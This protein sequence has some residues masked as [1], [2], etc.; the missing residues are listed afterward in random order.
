MG[1][2]RI[3]NG[4]ITTDNVEVT[5][6]TVTS[7]LSVLSDAQID[8]ELTVAGRNVLETIDNHN[9]ALENHANSI[10]D[11]NPHLTVAEHERFNKIARLFE[12]V[13]ADTSFVPNIIPSLDDS[14]GT[15]VPD[16]WFQ[17]TF[18]KENA[19]ENWPVNKAPGKV[20]VSRVPY[21]A[22]DD[23]TG[24][25]LT[26]TDASTIV[27]SVVYD[28]LAS[29]LMDNTDLEH[30]PSTDTVEGKDDYVGK[31]WAFFWNYGNFARDEYGTKHI[32]AV[33]D[34]TPAWSD[35]DGVT[36]ITG[37]AFDVKKNTAA[38]GP[39]FWF[40]CKVENYTDPNGE[41][42]VYPGTDKPYT[43]LWGI[44]DSPWDTIDDTSELYNGIVY[45][46]LSDDRKADLEAHGITKND[47]HIWPSALVWTGEKYVIRPYWCEAAFAGGYA[48]GSIGLVS[49]ANAPLWNNM[50]LST[51]YSTSVNG[52]TSKMAAHGS[53]LFGFHTLFTI[54]KSAN[55]NSQ[56]LYSGFTS[57][58]V[59]SV[60]ASKATDPDEP[61]YIFPISATSHF[62]VG[63]TVR[64]WQT[65]AGNSTV[66]YTP[67]V[68]VQFGRIKAIEN[69]TFKTPIT[70]ANE[71]G[72]TTITLE[73]T[74]SLCLVI[75]PATETCNPVQPFIVC[76]SV[77]ETKAYTDQ[78]IY[79][80]CYAQQ[81]LAMGGETFNAGVNNTGVISK[82]DGAVTSLTNGRHPYR[83]QGIEFLAG[84]WTIGGDTVA[85][86]GTGSTEV[87]IQGTGYY[88]LINGVENID[89][90]TTTYTPATTE[91]VFLYIPSHLTKVTSGTLSAALSNGWK[92]IGV[93]NK[94]AGWILNTQLAPTGLIY[95]VLLGTASTQGHRDEGYM[96]TGNWHELLSGGNCAYGATAGSSLLSVYHWLSAAL[97]YYASRL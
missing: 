35:T 47:F 92:V 82:Y 61:G 63:S 72:T 69:R 36:T 90:N 39:V 65:N 8:G 87:Q 62:N 22:K 79:A 34:F 31:Q 64:L 26:G 86:Q 80:C 7:H 56:S 23:E 76:T 27:G 40:F 51:L 12:E 30:E 52:T 28:G 66:G 49:K 93:T 60:L 85:M 32:T 13:D 11:T 54:V 91:C 58:D 3:T 19:Q 44:S 14:E 20:Y 46:G 96:N 74:T 68:S 42:L 77:E 15:I 50:S 6:N 55:K 73:E 53:N 41:K 88:H 70:T 16:D 37:D 9:I 81:C 83:I 33:K 43:Q 4:N 97:W 10:G 95:P 89:A 75:D 57:G 59:G 67:S 29:K 48:L 1:T 17:N 78:G 18:F 94:G 5:N 2:T 45:E 38:F 25:I 21:A 24:L 71:D 84:C